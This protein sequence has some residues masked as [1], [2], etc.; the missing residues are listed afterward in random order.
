[1]GAGIGTDDTDDGSAD[2][3]TWEDPAGCDREVGRVEEPVA[4]ALLTDENPEGT[5]RG[6]DETPLL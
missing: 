1:V 3:R 4:E 6:A 5:R 2:E